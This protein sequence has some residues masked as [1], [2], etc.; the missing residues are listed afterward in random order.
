MIRYPSTSLLGCITGLRYGQAIK[1]TIIP[2]LALILPLSSFCS[3]VTGKEL[4]NYCQ[5]VPRWQRWYE[6]FE[7]HPKDDAIHALYALRWGL[8]R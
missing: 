3:A 7:K 6:L 5:Y 4:S 2:A 8:C 1:T